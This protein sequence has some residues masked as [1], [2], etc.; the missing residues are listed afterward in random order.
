MFV[1]PSA[2]FA[3]LQLETSLKL[4]LHGEQRFRT[5]ETLGYVHIAVVSHVSR[6]M[7]FLLALSRVVSQLMMNSD[8]ADEIFMIV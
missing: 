4:R 7:Y 8:L 6:V 3:T 5:F 2:G 1:L